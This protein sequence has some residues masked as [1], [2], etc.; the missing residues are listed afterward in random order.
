M[1]SNGLGA[2]PVRGVRGCVKWVTGRVDE[3]HMGEQPRQRVG[4]GERGFTLIELLVVV[5][6]LGVLTSVAV[7]TYL[8]QRRKAVDT[9]L[10]ADVRSL[11]LAMETWIA[12]N[13]GQPGTDDPA[14]LRAAGFK[15]SSNFNFVYAGIN[16]TNDGYCLVASNSRSSAGNTWNYVVYDSLAGGLMNNG[17]LWDWSGTHPPGS[18]ACVG[19]NAGVFSLRNQ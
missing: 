4:R 15:R 10:R 7:P 2:P 17:R 5:I 9:S 14:A 11:A 8:H 12:D 19:A 13:P 16:P 3:R 1:S 18:K 6:V